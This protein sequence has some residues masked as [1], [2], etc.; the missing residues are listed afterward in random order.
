MR[1]WINF[2]RSEGVTS[3]Q[4]HADF[5]PQGV[6]EREMGRSGFFGPAAHFHHKHPPTAWSDWQ[7]ELRPRAFDL[8]AL[9]RANGAIP[10][11]VNSVLHNAHCRFRMWHCNHNMEELWQMP[12]VMTCY[13][14]MQAALTCFAILGICGYQR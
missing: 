5:P 9:E 12:T 7:G 8:N 10:W 14:F 2:P 3:K 6:F 4:A 13:L 1:K 11:M